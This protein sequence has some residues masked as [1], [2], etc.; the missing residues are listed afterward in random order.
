MAAKVHLAVAILFMSS[1]GAALSGC[2][3]GGAGSAAA[4]SQTNSTPSSASAASDTAS[5]GAS[6]YADGSIPGTVAST[7]LPPAGASPVS[8]PTGTA[9]SGQTLAISG[10][11]APSVA[12]GTAYTFHPS[13]PE[14]AAKLSFTI[15]NKPA[16]AIF[17]T[18]TGALSGTP[19]EAEVGTYA[20]ILISVS[21]GVT[22]TALAPFTIA[23]TPA[24][25]SITL[26]WSPPTLN[27]NGT[28]IT[29]LAGY[30]IHYGTSP[31]ALNSVIMVASA[32]TTNQVV[33][34]LASGTW[35]FAMTSYNAENIE[36]A[37]TA[38]L[39]VTVPPV[40]VA[41]ASGNGN[42]TAS[43]NAASVDLSA[44]NVDAVASVG[45]PATDGGLDGRGNAYS[46]SALGTSLT[47]SGAAFTLPVPGAKSAVRSATVAL[48][49]GRFSSLQI[50]ATGV[51]G[52]Q[53]NQTFTVTY[54]DG[55]T[56][57]ITQSLSDWYTPQNYAGESLA[58]EMSDRITEGGAADK[59]TFNAYG[60]RFGINGAKMVQSLKLPRNSNVVVLAA[61]LAN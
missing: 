3:G 12:A 21:D 6:A 55:S 20:Q 49:A 46:A 19:T 24:L 25:A 44:A 45:S 54:T 61:A 11:P 22:S 37:M 34:N 7:A 8:A 14:L 41:T 56:D 10:S 29:D 4:T 31:T 60:Y 9:A 17:D 39:Q 30:R 38:V 53:P 18:G 16:W 59:R 47:W 35:Y 1:L 58:L 32:T 36:S 13:V 5:P 26:S 51:N 52:N 2:S 27:V 50:L 28:S 15:S 43:G 33:G 57:T 40:V 23:V 48:P 42:A